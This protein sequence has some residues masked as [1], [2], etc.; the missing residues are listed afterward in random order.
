MTFEPAHVLLSGKTTVVYLKFL[1]DV[2]CTKN[3]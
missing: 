1:R 2:A 3:Y